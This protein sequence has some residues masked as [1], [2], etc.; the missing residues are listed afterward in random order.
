M[1]FDAQAQ[2]LSKQHNFTGDRATPQHCTEVGNYLDEKTPGRWMRRGGPI[3]MP[4]YSPD[5]TP[6]DY[7]FVGCIEDKAYLD[8]PHNLRDLTNNIR[9]EIQNISVKTL[10]NVYA[11]MKTRLNLIFSEKG[12][13]SSIL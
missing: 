6:C 11:N 2:R 10:S 4:A 9:R 12:D 8:P 1:L 5:L 7:F 13:A 3:S